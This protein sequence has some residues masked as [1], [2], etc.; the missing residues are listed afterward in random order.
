ML[1]KTIKTNVSTE[2]KTFANCA[3]KVNGGKIVKQL[4]FSSKET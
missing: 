3:G 1:R 4:T 2:K